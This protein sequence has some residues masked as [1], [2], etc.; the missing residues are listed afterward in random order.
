MKRFLAALGEVDFPS[1]DNEWMLSN[2]FQKAKQLWIS[3]NNNPEN[4]DYKK[5][6][7]LISKHFHGTSSF[8]GLFYWDSVGH[9]SSPCRLGS[10]SRS[11]RGSALILS[12]PATALSVLLPTALSVL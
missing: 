4:K 11:S 5:A 7:M 1:D 6:S 12:A 10:W 2:D 3:S 9:A 8:A